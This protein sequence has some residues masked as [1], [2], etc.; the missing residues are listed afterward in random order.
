MV[1]QNLLGVIL[2]PYVPLMGAY[3]IE[4]NGEII[5]AVGVGGAL[6]GENDELIAKY[7]D[8]VIPA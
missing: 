5:G 1:M 2:V 7:A 4:L 3:P 8:E 6:T